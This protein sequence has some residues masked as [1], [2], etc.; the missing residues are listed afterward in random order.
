MLMVAPGSPVPLSV[1]R[2]SLVISPVSSGPVLPGTSSTTEVI[3]GAAGSTL[4]TV[5]LQLFEVPLAFPASSMAVAVRT[6][7]PSRR[8]T[9]GVNSQLPLWG[10]TRV[11]I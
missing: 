3:T 1:G 8:W 10:I 6:W 5:M 2:E 9:E 4:S 7:P 11:P